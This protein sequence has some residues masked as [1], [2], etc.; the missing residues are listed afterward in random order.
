[1]LCAAFSLAQTGPEPLWCLLYH[2]LPLWAPARCYCGWWDVVVGQKHCMDPL[3]WAAF[4]LPTLQGQ[5]GVQL[6]E[7]SCKRW[8]LVHVLC[9]QIA[10]VLQ[11][12][13][14]LTSAS[15]QNLGRE[16]YLL[17]AVFLHKP[18]H[19]NTLS[20]PCLRPKTSA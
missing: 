2:H 7:Q 18:C 9:K 5:K 3:P 11:E 12:S 14:L 6:P 13:S 16:L 10:G 15:S 19:L 20:N 17:Q 1:M 8:R 4:P